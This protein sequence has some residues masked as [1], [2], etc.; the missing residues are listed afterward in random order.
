VRSV[1]CAGSVCC[2]PSAARVR[3][4]HIDRP[5]QA[6]EAEALTAEEYEVAEARIKRA[7]HQAA[8]RAASFV[9]RMERDRAAAVRLGLPVVGIHDDEAARALFSQFDVDSNGFIGAEEVQAAAAAVLLPGQPWDEALWPPMCAQYGCAADE[10]FD[11]AAFL[12]FKADADA[13]RASE[14]EAEPEAEEGGPN[15]RMPNQ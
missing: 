1:V 8:Q 7:S 14:P 12:A 9:E 10:G 5:V 6:L 11:F 4:T 3:C 2:R 13:A 15:G